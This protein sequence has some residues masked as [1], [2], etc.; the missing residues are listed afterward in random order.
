MSK[1]NR[2]AEQPDQDFKEKNLI[3]Y[4]AMVNAWLTTKLE[5]DKHL[6]S[7]STFA[8]GLLVTLATTIGLEN[9]YAKL[10]AFIS[11]SCFIVVVFTILSI[12]TENAS[13]VLAQLKN[14]EETSQPLM[15][16]LKRLDL[17]ASIFFKIGVV[18]LVAVAIITV[19]TQ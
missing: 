19:V 5:L 4:G 8:V 1:K 12:F 3:F 13:M 14:D 18:T 15:D 2:K 7:L 9:C 10:A 16:K 6:L 11:A 17:I